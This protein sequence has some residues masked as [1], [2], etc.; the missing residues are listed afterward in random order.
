MK[1]LLLLSESWNDSLAPNNNMTNWFS[2]FSDVKIWTIAGSAQLPNNQCCKD[3]FL[4][5]EK[6]M[7]KSIIS[8]K[9]VGTE[10]HYKSYPDF[11]SQQKNLKLSRKSKI[12]KYFAS[13][14]ARFIRDCIWRYGHYD[15]ETMRNFV[16]TFKPDIVFTQ[17]RGSIK[18]CRLEGIVS[19]FTSAPIVAYTGDDEY[20]LHQFSFSPVFWLRRLW[21]RR[22]LNK[23]IPMYKLF[24]S[25]SKRQIEEFN[26][27]FRVPTK[28]LVKCG[29]FKKEKV[30]SVVGTPI[31]LI[32][33]GKLYC[34]RWKTLADIA[35]TIVTIN[36]K[37]NS[38]KLQL[39]IYTSDTIT[40]KQAKKLNDG[41]NSIIHDAVPASELPSIYAHSDI[42][43]HVEAFDLK[44]RLLTQDSFSTKVMDCMASGCA[45]MAVCWNGHAAYQYLKEKDAAIVADSNEQIKKQL[46]MIVKHPELVVEYAEKAFECGK[47]SHQRRYVQKMLKEDFYKVI[48]TC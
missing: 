8:G 6:E 18:M 9:T 48:N 34:N 10:L 36:E 32:Y 29:D 5:D 46:E 28:F 21:V 16:Q 4:I 45:V 37:Y 2:N 15:L 13:E 31:Q 11:S 12:K 23:T 41:I 19:S 38:T 26:N 33:A 17:R 39:N 14:S 25:Q 20:S 35:R 47:R 1:I 3:Y 7:L 44:N 27:K 22:W 30:H 24:Y 42:V 40:R 43:L